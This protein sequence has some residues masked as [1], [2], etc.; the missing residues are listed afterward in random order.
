MALPAG[1]VREETEPRVYYWSP[2]RSFRFGERVQDPDPGGPYAV[3]H[4]QDVAARRPSGPYPG[5][6]D[7]V[8][9]RTTQHGEEAALWEFTYDGFAGGGGARR[10]FDLCWT[11]DGRM[12]DV[13]VSGP[14][15]QVE[16][17]RAVF[18]TVRATFTP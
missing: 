6:R 18:D 5:Y 8:I 3:M 11:Q 14:V 7:G 10:T 12:Y 15:T 4:G 1:Y 13:W 16:R 2:D 17:T 9:T